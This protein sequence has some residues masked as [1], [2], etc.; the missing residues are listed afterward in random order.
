VQFGY[1]QQAPNNAESA[2]ARFNPAGWKA[3]ICLAMLS[4]AYVASYTLLLFPPC[5]TI[6]AFQ[7]R[8]LK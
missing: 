1:S 8:Q 7:Q 4:I 2:H 6:N 5:A 3:F